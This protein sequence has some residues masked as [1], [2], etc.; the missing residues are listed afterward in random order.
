MSRGPA[1]VASPAD[2]LGGE[3]LALIA[4]AVL[5]LRS[6]AD[7]NTAT[8]IAG[9]CAV[10][11]LG[12]RAFR[13]LRVDPRS[14]AL[15]LLEAGGVETPYVGEQ[16][17]AIEW[18]L[19]HERPLYDEGDG[20]DLP[21]R[22]TLLWAQ[23]P[24]ALATIPLQVRHTPY[25]FLVLAFEQPH[26]FAPDERLFL[27]ALADALALVLERQELR[28]TL[29]ETRR[30]AR[31]LE[32]RLTR[33]EE[34]AA[35]LVAAVAHEMQMP[36]GAIQAYT[37]TLRDNLKNAHAPRERFLATIEE[38]CGRLGRLVSDILELSRLEVGQ[39]PL[40]VESVEL[41]GQIGEVTSA[42]R[43]LARR[44]RV[45]IEAAVEQPFPVEGDPELLRQLWSSLL[46]HAIRYSPEGGRVA[47]RVRTEGD[48]WVAEVSDSGPRVS[49]EDVARVFDRFSRVRPT[50]EGSGD[51]PGLGLAIARGI[52]ELHGGQI[53]ARSAPDPGLTFTMR[54]P[55]R[56]VASPKA[57]RI[58]RQVIRHDL[59]RQL[60]EASVEMVAEVLEAEVA[61]FMLVDAEEGDL[62]VAAARG[63]SSSDLTGRRV[64][65]RAGV[66]GTVAASGKPVRVENIE[67]DRRFRRL[68][69][70]QYTT[71]SLLSVP[72]R[73]E[74]EVMGVVNVSNKRTREAFSE[75]DLSVLV[76][77]VER[78]GGV[79]ERGYAY[80]GGGQVVGEALDAVRS[81]TAMRAER[82][83]GGTRAVRWARA[84][85]QAMKVAPG[86]VDVLGYVASV[87]D[88]GMTRIEGMLPD[89][90]EP[91]DE[92]GR[93]LV[94]QHPE[95]S[96]EMI[97]PL[98]Y[99]GVVRDVILAHHEW[100]DGSGYP[101]GLKG[102][103]IPMAARILAVVD[104]YESMTAGR[105]HRASLTHDEAVL[106][107]RRYSG[108][109]FDPDVLE[110]FIG[111]LE[112]ERRAW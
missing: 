91:L 5:A 53:G 2:R 34:T 3:G 22:E 79:I 45:E 28:R 112:R 43:P 86:E 4:Q 75:D 31:E 55:M 102:E 30:H 76:A 24:R 96:V 110:A 100:W 69:H 56:Q 25:G 47:V 62:F 83:L 72:L 12:A 37:E 81:V 68:N 85:A 105:P 14:G 111:M 1:A 67:T 42:L 7:L 87:H 103:E 48:D 78:I 61:S 50:P 19:R 58:S 20:A 99:Q 94:M 18:A 38:E 23:P 10:H 64:P 98:E 71:K 6:T 90:G 40:R 84:T 13:L 104:A 109:Q 65:L 52:V 54:L 21:A 80:P 9:E 92:D 27:H 33:D 26:H 35:G 51:G 57:R 11:A 89:A 101:R 16:G 32:A 108:R 95:V 73:V 15:Q 82:R 107:L 63:V 29:D 8:E 70:P 60:F 77:L 17:G 106:E 88:V 97:R 66:A 59:I 49:E 46:Q 44:R 93:N 41:R 39:R 36:V 74:G